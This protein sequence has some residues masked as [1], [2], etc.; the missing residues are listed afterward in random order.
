MKRQIKGIPKIL[1]VTAGILYAM[2]FLISCFSSKIKP[3]NFSYSIYFS[4]AFPFLFAGYV[5][6]AL[7]L[8]FYFFR[9]SLWIAL[10][11]AVASLNN[12]SAVFGFHFPH[13]FQTAK[14]KDRAMVDAVAQHKIYS[15]QLYRLCTCQP[16]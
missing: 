2:F 4:L 12:V 13:S 11:I 7:P 16:E 15:L 14:Q 10:L 3:C 1:L 8:C 5:F 6:V 9:K